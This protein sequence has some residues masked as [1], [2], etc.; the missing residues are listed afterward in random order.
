M[1]GELCKNRYRG[2][3]NVA[4]KKIVKYKYGTGGF[5]ERLENYAEEGNPIQ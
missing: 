1:A 2:V 3:D 4:M 5:M